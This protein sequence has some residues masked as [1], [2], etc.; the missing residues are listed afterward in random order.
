MDGLC[1]IGRSF[2][3]M[4]PGNRRAAQEDEEEQEERGPAEE[5]GEEGG[6][7]GIRRRLWRE[8]RPSASGEE[9]GALPEHSV[10]ELP[11]PPPPKR[12]DPLRLLAPAAMVRPMGARMGLGEMDDEEEE[13]EEE[14][15]GQREQHHRPPLAVSSAAATPITRSSSGPSEV[16]RVQTV[17]S[18]QLWDGI[19]TA[20]LRSGMTARTVAG[21]VQ[22]LIRAIGEHTTA[23]RAM[24]LVV[25]RQTH[26]GPRLARGREVEHHSLCH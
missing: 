4:S 25:G 1:G 2:A 11:L 24:G 21:H 20:L 13:E 22:A 23:R 26:A 12:L 10:A 16:P 15:D 3:A 8:I 5:E 19:G 14:E 9:G 17:L 7:G 18:E 6:G